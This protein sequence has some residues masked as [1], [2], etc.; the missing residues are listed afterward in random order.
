M[1]QYNRQQIKSL[2][3]TSFSDE[4][5]DQ[6]I[7]EVIGFTNYREKMAFLMGMFDVQVMYRNPKDFT[8][9]DYKAV[10]HSVVFH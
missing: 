5:A 8:E 2:I 3:L 10:L 7:E 4:E 1:K 6:Y 9:D